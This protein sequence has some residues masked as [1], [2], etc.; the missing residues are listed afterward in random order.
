MYSNGSSVFMTSVEPSIMNGI[1]SY[2]RYSYGRSFRWRQQ[3]A[4][5]IAATR[6]QYPTAVVLSLQSKHRQKHK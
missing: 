6:A 3:T 2:S 1:I 5:L 4:L